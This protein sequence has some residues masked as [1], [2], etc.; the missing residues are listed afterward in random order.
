MGSGLWIVDCGLVWRDTSGFPH[1][2]SLREVSDISSMSACSRW[3]ASGGPGCCLL[4]IEMSGPYRRVEYTRI[5]STLRICRSLIE[6]G[7]TRVD[8]AVR[9]RFFSMWIDADTMEYFQSRF[10]RQMDFLSG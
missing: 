10:A 1:A 5:G 4:N 6:R 9:W 8:V 3:N 7:S 2:V